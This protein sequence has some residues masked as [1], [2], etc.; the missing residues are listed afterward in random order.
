MLAAK[1]APHALR[2]AFMSSNKSPVLERPLTLEIRTSPP[3]WSDSEDE[4]A[5]PKRTRAV[6]KRPQVRVQSLDVGASLRSPFEEK[7]S[8]I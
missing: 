8:F 5:K 4:D 7:S 1:P 3:S 2:D 6:A